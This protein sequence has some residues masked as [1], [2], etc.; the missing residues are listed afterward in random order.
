MGVGGSLKSKM[1]AVHRGSVNSPC[2]ERSATAFPPAWMTVRDGFY[3]NE[4]CQV[5]TS[6]CQMTLRSARLPRHR[7]TPSGWAKSNSALGAELKLQ[8]PTK[9]VEILSSKSLWHG[10]RPP[11]RIPAGWK[12][13]VHSLLNTTP[14]LELYE[15]SDMGV[16]ISCVARRSLI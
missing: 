9:S 4:S 7:V 8:P 2:C 12:E 10:G 16:S 13:G 5:A 11:T 14:Q 3:R 15:F 1:D 6:M